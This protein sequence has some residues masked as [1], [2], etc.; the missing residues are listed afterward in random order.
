VFA[1]IKERVSTKGGGGLTISSARPDKSSMGLDKLPIIDNVSHLFVIARTMCLLK[2]GER[3]FT[4][5]VCIYTCMHIRSV[6]PVCVC[7]YI[8]ILYVIVRTMCLLKAGERCFTCYVNIYM[9]MRGVSPV[10]NV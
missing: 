3:C 1:C 9:Y 2:A 6:S 8:Y 7:M 4:C 5:Y 10:M